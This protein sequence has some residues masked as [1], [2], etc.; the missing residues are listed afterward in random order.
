MHPRLEELR[1]KEPPKVSDQHIGINGKIALWLTEKVGS[2]WTAYLF[3][4]FDLLFLP[5]AVKAGFLGIGTWVAQTFLQLVLLPVIMVGQDVQSKAADRRA[6]ETYKDTEA[7]L[8]ELSDLST[9]LNQLIHDGD[10][11]P[12]RYSDGTSTGRPYTD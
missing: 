11:Q 12:R 7:I 4:I 5:E 9:M 2:M 8:S 1:T 10:T 6:Q 3:A